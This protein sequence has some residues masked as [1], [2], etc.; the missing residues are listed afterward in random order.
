MENIVDKLHR[1]KNST[2]KEVMTKGKIGTILFNW[3]GYREKVGEV[4]ENCGGGREGKSL[5][6]HLYV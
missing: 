6:V 3:L 2:K 5:C 1:K 4:K